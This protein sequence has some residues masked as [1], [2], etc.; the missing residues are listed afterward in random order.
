MPGLEFPPKAYNLSAPEI[1]ELTEFSTWKTI[2]SLLLSL[3]EECPADGFD[4][5][6]GPEGTQIHMGSSD[7]VVVHVD[8]INGLQQVRRD[9]VRAATYMQLYPSF[10]GYSGLVGVTY[11]QLASFAAR[12]F[13]FQVIKPTRIDPAF[14]LRLRGVYESLPLSQKDDLEPAMIHMATDEFIGRFGA[15]HIGMDVIRLRQRIASGEPLGHTMQA[16]QTEDDPVLR[17]IN[18][19]I[20]TMGDEK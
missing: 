8:Y 18:D 11:R 12:A 14:E 7:Y 17:A 3:E 13:G 19:T 4:P 9:I 16:E 6:S 15:R 20:A 10:R 5:S 2:G 1:A